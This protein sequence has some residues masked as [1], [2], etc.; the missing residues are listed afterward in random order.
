MKKTVFAFILIASLFS[1]GKEAKI[2]TA[3]KTDPGT[4][5]KNTASTLTAKS[6]NPT[7]KALE[8]I[9]F[10]TD[11]VKQH[12]HSKNALALYLKFREETEQL[13]SRIA[14]DNAYLLD[15]YYTHFSEKTNALILPDSLQL[16][17]KGFK[18]ANIEFQ[19]IG[20]GYVE[21][22]PVANYYVNIFNGKLP[23][24]YNDYIRLEA[25]EN[26]ELIAADAGLVI[27][28]KELSVLVLHWETFLQ[29]HPH[30]VLFK[31]VKE[32]YKGL[33]GMYLFGLDNTP[34]M[35]ANGDNVMEVYE[36]NQKEFERFTVQNPKSVTSK[37][38]LALLEGIKS[39]LE[40][41]DLNKKIEQEFL[42]YT[43]TQ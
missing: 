35:E 21:V 3:D 16:K 8:E 32:K 40:P 28:F 4:L 15:N 13:V 41:N 39:H 9:I 27:S 29:K 7:A 2:K 37:L 36:E 5:T 20:E 42:K 17:L 24:D 31:Q 30:S 43:I 19:E 38:V 18:K 14:E 34:T 33:L 22:R 12:I 11:S 10:K 25:F 23:T 6:T 1:C 26:K